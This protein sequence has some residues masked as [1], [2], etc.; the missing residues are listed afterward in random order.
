MHQLDLL[1]ARACGDAAAQACLAKAEGRN[2]GF[3]LLACAFVLT[4]LTKN[5]PSPGEDIVAAGAAAGITSH[6]ARAWGSIFG[7]MSNKQI[8]CIRSDLPRKHGH[9]TSGGKLWG[10]IR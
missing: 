9:G 1:T 4:Y 2:P 3:T 10:L 5:G 7:R 6:D 8:R